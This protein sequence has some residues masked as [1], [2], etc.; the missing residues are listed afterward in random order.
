[1]TCCKLLLTAWKKGLSLKSLTE[2]ASIAS[3]LKLKKNVCMLSRNLIS[4]RKLIGKNL[5]KSK[6][7][8]KLNIFGFG[9]RSF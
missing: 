6:E 1:M 2:L 3:K 8:K 7:F 9:N 5:K 4:E